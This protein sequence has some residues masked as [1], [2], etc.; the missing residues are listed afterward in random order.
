MCLFIVGIKWYSNRLLRFRWASRRPSR[1]RVPSADSLMAVHVASTPPSHACSRSSPIHNLLFR[2]FRALT[3]AAVQELQPLASTF[4]D[5]FQSKLF[6]MADVN[7]ELDKT[8]EGISA[9]FA[10]LVSLDHS[11]IQMDVSGLC[12]CLLFFFAIDSN[13]PSCI[14]QS[15]MSMDFWPASRSCKP[16]SQRYMRGFSASYT[17]QDIRKLWRSGLSSSISHGLVPHATRTFPTH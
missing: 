3:A 11:I 6:N 13:S 5:L 2:L 9:D 1:F 15:T 14:R 16:W 17:L 8:V 12:V 10:S 4:A 7:L